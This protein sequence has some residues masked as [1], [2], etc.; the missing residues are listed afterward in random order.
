MK[1]APLD[2]ERV[3]RDALATLGPHG[4]ARAREALA[5]GRVEIESDV[6]RWEGT[7]GRVHGH[8]LTLG[9]DG[10]LLAQARGAPA[11]HDALHAALAASVAQHGNEA[12]VDLRLRWDARVGGG[13]HPYRGAN[14]DAGERATLAEG[15]AAYLAA[16]D[17]A[18]GRAASRCDV[19][20]TAG[21]PPVAVA[22]RC[23]A[24]D[25]PALERARGAVEEAL[26]ALLDA[27]AGSLVVAIVVVE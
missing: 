21:A 14:G 2:G 22:L 11:V 9:L 12:L 17:A 1:G 27:R 23:R 25:A 5:R 16:G 24:A 3:R 10:A 15:L 13:D 6:T 19:T 20:A 4:D 7:A 8:R 26:A 18:L